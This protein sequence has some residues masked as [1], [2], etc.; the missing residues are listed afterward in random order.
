[1]TLFSPLHFP[2]LVFSNIACQFC[3]SFNTTHFHTLYATACGGL[4]VAVDGRILLI[5]LAKCN[6][7]TSIRLWLKS[8]ILPPA[9]TQA[10]HSITLQSR[11][12]QFTQSSYSICLN[13]LTAH[14]KLSFSR[15]HLL[16]TKQKVSTSNLSRLT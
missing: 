7:I 3:N 10:A 1:M 9:T 4:A 13:S 2:A 15:V 5:H 12:R 14:T 11:I 16:V 8:L 6:P